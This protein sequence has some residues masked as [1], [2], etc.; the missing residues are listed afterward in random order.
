MKKIGYIIGLLIGI[1]LFVVIINLL[2]FRG[3]N[4]SKQEV[5]FYILNSKIDAVLVESILPKN[6][7]YISGISRRGSPSGF[8]YKYPIYSKKYNKHFILYVFYPFDTNSKF[9]YR[10]LGE[11]AFENGFLKLVVRINQKQLLNPKYGTK[12]NPISVFP[13]DMLNLNWK[14]SGYQSDPFHVSEKTNFLFVEQ[15]LKF[16]MPKEEFKE[17]FRKE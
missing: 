9:R 6:Q 13:V 8:L 3:N 7:Q 5:Q 17:M 16:F 15:Y 1:P 12:G 2:F 10:L 14:E 11:K 4:P